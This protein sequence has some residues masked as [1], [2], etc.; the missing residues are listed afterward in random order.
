MARAQDQYLVSSD[1]GGTMTDLFVTDLNGDFVVGK[2][3][4]TPAN[5]S[6]GF[7][8]SLEDAFTY[9]EIDL[10]KNAKEIMPRILAC[11]YTG[12]SMLNALITRQGAKVGL[13]VNKG[14]EQTFLTTRGRETTLGYG[15][16]EIFHTV[17]RRR[18]ESYVP[19]NQIRGVTGKIDI[20]GH[21]VIPLY[22]DEVSRA[23]TELLDLDVECIAV[24]FLASFANPA[25]E[26]RA[27]EIARKI[28]EEKGKDIPVITSHEVSPYIKE[29]SRMNTLVVQAYAGERARKQ[30]FGIE[31]DLKKDG[32]KYP[33]QMVLSYGT[34]TDIRWPRVV[35]ATVSGPVGGM[36]GAKYLGEQIGE[37][38]WVCSDV[39]GTSF[40]VGVIQNGKIALNREPE[41]Q[42]MYLTLPMLDVRSIGAGAGTYIRL[43]EYTNRIK[44]GPDSASGTPGPVAY[45]RGNLTP[46]ICDCGLLLGRLNKDYFLGGKI[47]LDVDL[48]Y[49]TFKEKIAD[50]LHMDVYRAAE[51]MI[52]LLDARMA[53]HLVSTVAGHDPRDFVLAGFG[54][55]A[56][57][58]LAAYSREVP[59]K[60]VCT[61]PWA[62][63]FSAF[64]CAAMDY[65]H[66]YANSIDVMIPS[67]PG[68]GVRRD[69]AQQIQG[70]LAAHRAKALEDFRAEGFAA[71]KIKCTPFFL[72]KFF[73]QIMDIEVQAPTP[74]IDSPDDVS[75]LI[76]EFEKV[77]RETYTQ[78]GLAP[79]TPYQITQVGVTATADKIK[80]RI[81]EYDLEGAEPPRKAFKGNKKV[82]YKGEWL[83]TNVYELDDLRAG[84]KV[85]GI[86]IF[87][88]PAYTLFIPPDREVEMD[89]HKLIWLKKKG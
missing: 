54:G 1:A 60:G 4:T 16:A 23:V 58:H 3:A 65:A 52:D 14:F 61:V 19:Y 67:N 33:L 48:A 81:T 35:E 55:A 39:G 86:A 75:K 77:Y 83:I 47:K 70:V 89:R 79:G 82:F 56:G 68:E 57:L 84:N 64:G 6:L 43:D 78:V 85:R 28:L 50:K 72:M 71:E 37:R 17:Y 42:R 51:L 20:R 40:D 74:W 31:A 8:E 15:N 2:A 32:F 73:G 30:L 80:P 59:W 18:K 44:L 49:K 36:L 63:G 69:V 41:F 9:W 21:E 11:V 5:E 26:K 62:A 24:C 27:A 22:E 88:A 66:R 29:V 7:R 34:V 76:A 10:V 12:T 53:Q 38:N 46:T 87:E 45:G 25:H 13:I